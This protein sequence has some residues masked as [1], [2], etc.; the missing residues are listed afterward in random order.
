MAFSNLSEKLQG[1]LKKLRGKGKISEADLKEAM[2]EVRL[3]LLEA[4]V[5]FK[6]VKDF[7]AKVSEKAMGEEVMKSL[8]PGQMIIKIVSDELT[9]LMGESNEK[10]NISSK[11]PTVIM[12]VGLQG[13][14]KT[15][16]SAK[17]A[18]LL[19]K[20]GKHPL[21]VACDV[22]RPAA[23]NQLVVVGRQINIPVFKI[24]DNRDP[25]DIAKQGIKHAEKNG[26][27]VVIIDTAGRLHVDKTLMDEL[28]SIKNH[29][30]ISETLL[31]ID[32]M[33][34]QDIVNVATT[35]N[36]QLEI[37][38]VILTKL[39]GDA[40]GGAALSVRA[41]TGKPIKFIGV[42]EKTG[43]FEPFHPERMAQRILG[44]G[45]VLTLIERAEQVIDEEKAE[46]LQ[47]K[48]LNQQF[49]LDDFLD[50]LGQIKKMGPIS[51][52]LDMLPG[53]MGNI[54]QLSNAA[55]DDRKLAQTE[56]I[57]QSMTSQERQTPSILNAGRKRRVALGSGTN[58]SDVNQLLK[59]FNQMNDMMKQFGKKKGKFKLP[60]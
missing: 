21:L 59:Q 20:Q 51:Q 15:T 7:V 26:L 5:N 19:C 17:L 13:A 23:I 25:L 48:L 42:G 22:Y 60:F 16:T 29:L 24:D 50:Q 27:D 37:D 46:E 41:S 55:V 36:E 28:V 58:V 11:P 6:I 35:F 56:A 43:D 2:R 12:M 38:G 10:I 53:G 32:A 44:M 33:T 54:K 52:F 47:Q 8:T 18:G 40:R 1:V 3:A 14:G 39:D 31:V 4:D 45:D 57:I 9:S 49:T 30:A 34:G